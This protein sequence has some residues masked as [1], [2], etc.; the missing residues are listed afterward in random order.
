MKEFSMFI[1][2][3]AENSIRAEASR[4]K[5]ETVDSIVSDIYNTSIEDNGK[6]MDQEMVKCCLDPFFSTRKTRK[7]GLG[8]PLIKQYAQMAG[9]DINL[10]S[11][12]G[13]GTKLEISMVRSNIDRVP[14][15]DIASTLY[16]ILLSYPE[17]HLTYKHKSDFGEYI[18][19]SYEILELMDGVSITDSDITVAIKE[20]IR[21]SMKD[22]KAN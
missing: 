2:D 22:I 13:V 15:G 5:I 7:I 1:M 17:V 3:L 19:D 4:V 20:L 10:E 9:G 21:N 12:V 14:L 6:G 8:L 16:L 18:Y 11:E